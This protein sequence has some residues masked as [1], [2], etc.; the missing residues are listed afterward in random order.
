MVRLID[1]FGADTI[2][3][4]PMLSSSGQLKAI[5]AERWKALSSFVG[6]WWALGQRSEVVRDTADVTYALIIFL[7]S[8]E[9]GWEVYVK[10]DAGAS[11][12]APASIHALRS[13]A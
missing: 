6:K 7:G 8:M 2:S 5:T 9:M 11:D 1:I 10:H 4:L 13:R 3:N 12:G